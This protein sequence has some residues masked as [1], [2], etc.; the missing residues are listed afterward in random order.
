MLNEKCAVWAEH[1]RPALH[2]GPVDLGHLAG[3]VAGALGRS[4]GRWTQ[5]G[6][7]ALDLVDRALIA[8]AAQDLSH[9]RRLDRRPLGEHLAHQRRV[10]IDG[11]AGRL[12][13]VARRLARTGEPVIPSRSAI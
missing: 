6:Q 11:R 4:H 5:L 1:A 7:A 10:T 3:G 2:L 9:A 13:A 12:A 8:M